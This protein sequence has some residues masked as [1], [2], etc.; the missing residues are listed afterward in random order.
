MKII[1]THLFHSLCFALA[2]LFTPTGWAADLVISDELITVNETTTTAINYDDL[3]VTGKAEFRVNATGASNVVTVNFN[4]NYLPSTAQ[5]T[6]LWLLTGTGTGNSLG[7]LGDRVEIF[8]NN[9][10]LPTAI[11]PSGTPPG[12][13]QPIV[14]PSIVTRSPI[15]SQQLAALLQDSVTGELMV[16]APD[17]TDIQDPANDQFTRFR[18]ESASGADV[19]LASDLTLYSVEVN[20]NLRTSNASNVLTV[21]S[22]SFLLNN[23]GGN[24][25]STA[26]INFADQTGY[27]HGDT[28]RDWTFSN[29][30][31]GTAG[32]VINDTGRNDSIIAFGDDNNT[33]T[34]GLVIIGGNVVVTGG[35]EGSGGDGVGL[36]RDGVHNNL[37]LGTTGTFNLNG[38]I[39]WIGELTGNGTVMNDSTTATTLGIEVA[40]GDVAEF[41]GTLTNTTGALSVITTGAGTQ[42]LSGN[43]TYT[44]DT[45]ILDGSLVL[46]ETGSLLFNIGD[47]EINNQITGSGDLLLNGTLIL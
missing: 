32:I 27:I 43:N 8:F 39:Q 25:S 7:T 47:D 18:S 21:A 42:I 37:Y 17:S 35:T 1:H 46:A 16:A 13:W 28:T 44:G 30:V 19:T 38:R 2:L 34:G 31:Q 41:S 12:G 36:N 5:P 20:G 14:H 40:D 10:Q 24:R 26:I 9:T 29:A 15:H 3:I 45:Q 11:T 23:T 22:G 33:F 4:G 6:G